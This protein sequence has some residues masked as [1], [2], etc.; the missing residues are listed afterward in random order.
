MYKKVITLS[1]YDRID[2][3]DQTLNALANC[4][5]IEDYKLRC[6][7]DLSPLYQSILDTCLHGTI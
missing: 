4:Y 7:I 6:F 5:G 3:L 2:Y 1:A